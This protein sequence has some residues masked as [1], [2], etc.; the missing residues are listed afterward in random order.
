MISRSTGPGIT[1]EEFADMPE[2]EHAELVRGHIVEEPANNGLHAEVVVHVAMILRWFVMKH[3]LGKVYAGD[4]GM[5][6]EPDPDTT[7]GPDIAFV[8]K[9]RVDQ[10]PQRGFSGVIAD[11]V[12]EVVSPS[13]RAARV[14]AKIEEFLQAGVRLAWLLDPG[15]ETLVEFHGQS[16][17]ELRGDDRVSGHD[18]LPGFDLAVRQL[19]ELDRLPDFMTTA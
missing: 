17:R 1:A 10:V 4:P 3:H 8:D 12:V 5:I 15:P 7:R 16:R 14:E 18:V 11:M 2:S 13:E 9:S 19:F 6:L